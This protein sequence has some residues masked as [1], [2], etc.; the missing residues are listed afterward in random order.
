LSASAIEVG[1]E[2]LVGVAGPCNRYLPCKR[3]KSWEDGFAFRFEELPPGRATVRVSLDGDERPLALVRGV[4][5]L[6]GQTNRDARL[7]GIDLTGLLH[8]LSIE[9]R[10]VRGS[11]VCD[12]WIECR[13]SG[14]TGVLGTVCFSE[15]GR[16]LL[17]RHAVLDLVVGAEGY[18][19]RAI[20]AAH[21]R[22]VVTLDAGL[23]I[24]LA[25]D[26]KVELTDEECLLLTVCPSRFAGV[27]L[28]SLHWGI[29][30][31]CIEKNRIQRILAPDAGECL[32]RW[33]YCGFEEEL[34][35]SPARIDL[36]DHAEEQTWTV[37]PDPAALEEARRRAAEE[38]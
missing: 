18:R 30:T 15:G 9:V 38:E 7:Q 17:S 12:G 25:L 1:I 27:P 33:Q 24:R 31:V 35:G 21:G 36:A 10:D 29:P 2:E 3:Y 22:V 13:A 34:P 32:L 28:E 23:P 20:V 37:M 8:Q 16:P 5:V 6:A 11:P 4:E 26:P 19:S 14:S